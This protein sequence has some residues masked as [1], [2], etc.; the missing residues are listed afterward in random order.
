MRIIDLFAGCGGMSLGFEMAGFQASLASEIDHWASDTYKK[1]HKKTPV[2]VEDIRKVKDLDSIKR[3]YGLSHVDGVIGGPPCQGFSLSGNRDRKDPRN[4][5]F[6][7]FVRFVDYFQ[8]KFFVMENVKGIL[9]MKTANGEKV[10]DIIISEF[11]AVGY[12]VDFS[13]LN[14]MNYGVP[15]SRE[16]VFFIGLKKEIPYRKDKLF[17]VPQLRPNEYVSVEKAISDLPEIPFEKGKEF[18][19]YK[20]S[21]ANKYQKWIRE[22]SKGICNHVAM[23]H[24]QRLISRFK[25]IKWGQSV[26]DVPHEHSALKRGN[27]AVKSGKV[28]SQN[29]MRVNPHK[30]A[31]TVAASFQSNF[32]HPYQDRN[33]TAREGARLQSFPD[34][35][36]FCGS[37]TT[38]SWEK[39]LSQYQQIGNAVPPL[40]A[41]A[42]ALNISKYFKNL[43]GNK[44]LKHTVAV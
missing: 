36:I 8:P 1:N 9:S 43:Q 25:V 6:M 21:P 12:N 42:V 41:K 5:L 34:R 16:R 18:G 3:E 7:E 39:N 28:F 26:K 20:H 10:S 11:N 23:R 22:D 35:Y 32:I 33:F 44:A 31:P 24:T 19:E 17:P 38:M 40:L 27:P 15:Q 4:S 30:P 29:N 14:S 2:I 37:R 13:I